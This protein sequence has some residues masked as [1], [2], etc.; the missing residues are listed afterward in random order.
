[1]KALRILTAIGLLVTPV[2]ASDPKSYVGVVTD[3][4]CGVDH[5]AMKNGPETKC[6]RDCVG[7]SRSYKYALA[8]GTRI[9][10]LSDQETPAA[11][12]G[13]KVRI[14]GVL[15]TNTG[16]LKVERIERLSGR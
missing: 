14:T 7:D 12:A 9:Y 1:M 13:E 6:V 8:V 15:Y 2:Y 3:T 5:V 10:T 16:I 11:F 4:M